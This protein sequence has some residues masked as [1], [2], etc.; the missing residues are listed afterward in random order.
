[1]VAEQ[2]IRLAGHPG[3]PGF[4]D[5]IAS[6]ARLLSPTGLVYD[7][8]D[9]IYFFDASGAGDRMRQLTLSTLEVRTLESSAA[10]TSYKHMIWDG[11]NLYVSRGGGVDYWSFRS[12]APPSSPATAPRCSSATGR[13]CAPSRSPPA[14]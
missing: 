12:S 6:D 11:T 4:T 10:S 14:T 13:R 2:L 3:R 8:H 7:G 5:G 9:T 1:V